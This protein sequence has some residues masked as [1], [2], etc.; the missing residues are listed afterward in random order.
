MLTDR[1]LHRSPTRVARVAGGCYLLTFIAGAGTLASRGELRDALSFIAD[2][3]YLGVTFL[4]YHLFKPVHRGVSLLAA[5]LSLA[6]IAAGLADRLQ[7]ARVPVNNLVF[8]GGY[9]LL[10]GWLILRSRFLPHWLGWAMAGA[11]LG[12]LTFLSPSL[13]SA[14]RPYNMAPGIIGEALLIIWLLAVG[15]EA[16]RWQEQAGA[17]RL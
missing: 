14:L 15:I 1:L 16:R 5:L 10:I 13:A 12:W 2:L 6:G 11:G 9:C 3:G 8:F 4:F 7:L 17:L